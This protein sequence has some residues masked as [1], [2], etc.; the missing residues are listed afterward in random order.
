MNASTV[1]LMGTIVN[2]AGTRPIKV[3][4]HVEQPTHRS[5]GMF[6]QECENEARDLVVLFVQGEMASVQHIDFG[7]RHIPLERLFPSL[8]GEAN[9]EPDL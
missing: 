9:I 7:I 1:V 4:R 8:P 6:G 2:P 3:Q 5:D